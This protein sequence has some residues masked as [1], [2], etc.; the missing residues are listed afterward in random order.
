MYLVAVL[1]PDTCSAVLSLLASAVGI[2]GLRVL[3]KQ[4]EELP[5]GKK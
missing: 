5:I 3:T 4:G 1:R 2:T